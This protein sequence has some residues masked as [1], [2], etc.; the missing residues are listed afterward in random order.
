MQQ[1][2]PIQVR[3]QI[4]GSGSEPAIITPLV[5][6]TPADLEAELQ[7]ILPKRP[8]L[9]EWRVDFFES[10]ADTAQVIALARQIRSA[11]GA[12]PLL[13]TRRSATEG[14]QP[15]PLD[16][17]GVVDLL[18]SACE[19]QCVDLVD[20]E[21]SNPLVDLQRLR[22][23]SAAQGIAMVMSFHDFKRTPDLDTLL[24][25]FELAS[26]LGADVGKV[27]VMPQ[28][29]QDVLTLL[30]ATWQASRK[31]PLPLISM[32]MGGLGAVTRVVG[33][34]FGSAATFAV[35][36][37]PSAPGQIA[38]EELRGLLAGVRRASGG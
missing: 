32:A 12:V 21:L 24:H 19:A 26:Q 23:A 18:C 27:A 28:S 31:L 2:R 34:Q 35:G 16:E 8:D 14:G 11:A 5:G 20:Y 6:R 25:K 30:T 7:A 33:G 17:T 13:L 15:V 37:N 29:P 36:M 38:V 4:L 3:G 9:L 22:A 10:I 1:T